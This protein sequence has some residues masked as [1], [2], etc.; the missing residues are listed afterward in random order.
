M[1]REALARR[2]GETRRQAKLA[3]RVQA[4]EVGARLTD[5]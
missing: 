5:D 4:V 2:S 3:A 1:T